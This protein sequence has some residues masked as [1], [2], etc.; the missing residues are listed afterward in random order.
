MNSEKFFPYRLSQ[1]TKSFSL[2]Q[3]LWKFVTVCAG[4][5]KLLEDRQQT[6]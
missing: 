1:R 2:L 4:T 6:L 3:T 5:V